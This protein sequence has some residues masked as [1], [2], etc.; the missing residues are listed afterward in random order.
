MASLRELHCPWLLRRVTKAGVTVE[1]EVTDRAP[2]NNILM[3][4]GKTS[5]NYLFYVNKLDTYKH[6]LWPVKIAS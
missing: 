6:V 1:R 3:V 2:L 4:A 5:E